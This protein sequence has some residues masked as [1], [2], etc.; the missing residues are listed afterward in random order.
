MTDTLPV[1]K[2]FSHCSETFGE[3]RNNLE[4]CSLPGLGAA[5]NARLADRTGTFP[6][7]TQPSESDIPVSCSFEQQSAC[8]SLLVREVAL[9]DVPKSQE[10]EVILMEKGSGTVSGEH[11]VKEPQ[12]RPQPTDRVT[13][14]QFEEWHP[15]HIK[16]GLRNRRVGKRVAV[17]I[18]KKP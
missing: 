14:P 1:S 7:R 12:A 13:L 6:Q 8:S 2:Q 16:T 15:S 9:V 5:Q 11:D 17:R 18:R 4:T 10:T 3:I